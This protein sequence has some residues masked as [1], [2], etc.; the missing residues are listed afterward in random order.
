MDY[1]KYFFGTLLLPIFSAWLYGALPQSD[2]PLAYA[3]TKGGANNTLASKGKVSPAINLDEKSKKYHQF[4]NRAARAIYINDFLVASAFYDSAFLFRKNPYYDD[5]TNSIVVNH[6]AGCPEKNNANI[7]MLFELKRVDTAFLFSQLPK[8]V[9]NNEN[10]QYINALS[11]KHASKSQKAHPLEAPLREMYIADQKAHGFEDF[12]MSNPTEVQAA[13][14]NRVNVDHQNLMRFYNLYKK[15]GF[16]TEEKMGIMYDKEKRWS[17]TVGLLLGHFLACDDTNDV[18][19]CLSIIEC[20]FE[21]SN[22]HPAV[23]AGLCEQLHNQTKQAKYNF[24]HTMLCEVNGILYRPF[25]FYSDSLMKEVNTNRIAIGLDSFHVSQR[26][27]VCQYVGVKNLNTRYIAYMTH[28]L[29]IA[30]LSYGF[31]KYAC[32]QAKV[33]MNSGRIRPEKIL[34]AC[35]CAEK[36]Y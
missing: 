4:I 13:F 24:M 5:I 18:K 29:N 27:A 19:L 12:N 15:F 25:V 34:S 11:K 10:I 30:S 1:T 20:E 3:L 14:E 17:N 16:P 21:K 9:F 33:D 36:V 23:Y 8:R 6:K 22:I 2:M 35:N 26:Q 7:R 28:Y 31:V 32:E